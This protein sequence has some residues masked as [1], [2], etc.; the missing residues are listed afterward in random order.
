MW[1]VIILGVGLARLARDT[2]VNRSQRM[3][4]CSLALWNIMYPHVFSRE[5]TPLNETYLR[6]VQYIRENLI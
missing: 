4:D 2:K 3:V 5:I 1:R 6:T